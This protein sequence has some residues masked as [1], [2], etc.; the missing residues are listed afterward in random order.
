M[1]ICPPSIGQLPHADVAL[2][3]QAL[4]FPAA[5]GFGL[6]ELLAVLHHLGRSTGFLLGEALGTGHRGVSFVVAPGRFRRLTMAA[7]HVLVL[8]IGSTSSTMAWHSAS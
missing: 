8:G 1:A 2:R 6:R 4:F 3:Q 7:S 5:P